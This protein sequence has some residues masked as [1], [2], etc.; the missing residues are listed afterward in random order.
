MFNNPYHWFPN[1][2]FTDAYFILFFGVYIADTVVP[3]LLARGN[4]KPMIVRDRGSFGF[5]R[6]A[7][8][9]AFLVGAAF[10]YLNLGVASVE[11]QYVGL[12]MAALG[13][14]F[15]EWAIIKLGRFFSRVVEIEAGHELITDGPYRR[16][17]HPAYTG[18]VAI[19]FGLILALGTW[20][21]A[22]AALGMIL[23][24]TIYRIRVEE[25]V[26]EQSFGDAYRD[27]MRRTWRLFPGW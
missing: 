14:A 9:L 20:L 19:Y 2:V 24:A 1:Q 7:G 23:L 4:A 21:G 10:R 25:Q 11:F 18:M 12:V 5:I 3:K 16:I 6:I 15:R 17:R 22:I 27:Y 26:L 13:L 8:I